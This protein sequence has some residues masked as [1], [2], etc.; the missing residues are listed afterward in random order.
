ML[1]RI[2]LGGQVKNDKYPKVSVRVRPEELERLKSEARRA[3][4]TFADY[5]RLRL[6]IRRY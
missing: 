4:R 3:R 6:G 2:V 1:Q 5:V